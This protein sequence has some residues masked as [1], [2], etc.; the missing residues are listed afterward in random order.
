[1]AELLPQDGRGRTPR[2]HGAM[3]NKE[4]RQWLDAE[5][6]GAIKRNAAAPDP[7]I[8]ALVN[9]AAMSVRYALVTQ[10]LGKIADPAR[11]L[12]TLQ[13]AAGGK[14]AWD[15]RRFSTSVVVPWVAASQNVLGTSA[16]PYASK[17]LR[18][19]RLER[20]M[21]NVRNK[22]DWERLVILFEELE[23]A[24]PGKT[25]E[26]FRRVLQSL[27]RRMASHR[28]GYAIPQRISLARLQATLDSF[29]A[30]P[31]GGLR[32]LAVTTALLRTVGTGL[33]LFSRVVAQGINQPD[34]AGRAPGDIVCYC[35]SEADR[36][37]LVAEVKDQ[38]LTLTHV[39]ALSLKARQADGGSPNLLFAVPGVRAAD[40]EG[41]DAHVA[42]EWASGTNIHTIDIKA[43]VDALFVLLDE[44]WR[45]RLLRAIGDE[46]DVRQDQV[47]RKAWHDLL[48][49][50]GGN[51]QR[52]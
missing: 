36:I 6:E 39:R 51:R 10:L 28:F 7:E 8:D 27:V 22:G 5:W 48:L 16:E 25:V 26:V 34:V 38:E 41:I 44:R 3:N 52:E 37:C 15:A 4:A 24:D 11:S 46:L 30:E 2:S 47:A 50:A 40:R 29:L 13:L 42:S 1:M 45:V 43:L 23:A 21:P 14:G 12:L 31:S 20:R 32:P 49:S 17:P 33:S 18:R 9:T 19:E 35:H